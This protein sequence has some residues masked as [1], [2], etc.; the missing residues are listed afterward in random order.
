MMETQTGRKVRLLR[1]DNGGEY[2]STAM[3]TYLAGKGIVHETTAPYSPAD[4]GRSERKNRTLVEAA[5]TMMIAS[6]APTKTWTHAIATACHVQ[7]LTLRSR[8]AS[9]SPYECVFGQKPDFAHLKR[10]GCL[11]FAFTEQATR[12]MDPRGVKGTL[13]GYASGS[14]AYLVLTESG[15]VLSTKNVKFFEDK[16]GSFARNEGPVDSTFTIGLI[17]EDEEPTTAHI[18]PNSSEGSETDEDGEET[19]STSPTE[20]SGRVASESNG[21]SDSEPTIESGPA[22]SERGDDEVTDEGGSELAPT[23]EAAEPEAELDTPATDGEEA[24]VPRPPRRS[25]R[26]TRYQGGYTYAAIGGSDDSPALAEALRGPDREE[27]K[28]AIDKELDAHERNQTWTVVDAPHDRRP[29]ESKIILKK[30][31]GPSGEVVSL[32]ARLVARGFTQRW[33]VDYSETFAPV[34]RGSTI[35]AVLTAAAHRD[36]EIHQ[37]DVDTAYLNATVSEEIYMSPPKL[38]Q[39]E[40]PGKAFKLNKALYGLKQAGREWYILL[41]STLKELGWSKSE[42]DTCLFTRITGSGLEYL[43]IYVDDLVLACPNDARMAL[44]KEEIAGRFQVKDLGELKFVLG[45]QVTRDRA[46][47]TIHLSQTAYTRRVLER[48]DTPATQHSKVPMGKIQPVKASGKASPEDVTRYQEIV[49]SLMHLARFT[50]PDISTAVGIAARF[51]SNPDSGHFEMLE[52]ILGYLQSTSTLGLLLD[53]SAPLNI[54]GAGD[55]DWGGD[56]QDRKSTS[57]FAIRIGNSLI[58]WQSSKQ[59]CVSLSTMQAEYIAMTECVKEAVWASKLLKDLGFADQTPTI[60][61]DNQA[62]IA[63]LKN[64]AQHS[65]AKHIDIRYH[66]IKDLMEEGLLTVEYVRSEENLA[67][68]LTKPLGKDKFREARTALGVRD[69][70]E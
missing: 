35:F 24:E 18:E 60:R 10:F 36:M 25:E 67:D 58:S 16:F 57:G 37:L 47:K 11:C 28:E 20:Q 13:L 44:A 9:A 45:I 69:L 40:F 53:G 65:L 4:N 63:T 22:D 3:N 46:A 33:G 32:K 59:K 70:T 51:A 14:Q 31:R 30:K 23:D 61:C 6:K 43:V 42:A 38:L 21:P 50:R 68:I 39:G 17:E 66:F 1:T 55:A 54:V 29:I 49:G 19:D 12:K 7:N 8:F 15:K 2:C 52:R 41:A 34:S 5:R 26:T 48:L 56:M 64:E 27:W 62:A